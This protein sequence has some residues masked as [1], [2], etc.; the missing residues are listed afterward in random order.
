MEPVSTED[1]RQ[2]AYELWQRDGSPSGTG[3]EYWLRAEQE[4]TGGDAS[5]KVSDDP[6]ELDPVSTTPEA[7]TEQEPKSIR[8]AR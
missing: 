2:R 6:P 1:I 5:L 8:S 4:L 7:P 3:L